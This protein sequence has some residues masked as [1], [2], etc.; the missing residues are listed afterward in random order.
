MN[1]GNLIVKT[2]DGSNTIKVPELDEHYHSVNGAIQ[3]ALTVFI[4][5]GIAKTTLEELKILEIGF[6]TGLN[7]LLTALE[8]KKLN[9]RVSYTTIEKYPVQEDLWT[10]LDY[11]KQTGEESRD[12]FY[13]LHRS[14]WEKEVIINEHFSMFKHQTDL[15][16]FDTSEKFDIIYYDA[17]A[18]S[19]QPSLWTRDIIHKVCGFGSGSCNFLTYAATGELKRQLIACNYKVERLPGPTGKREITRAVKG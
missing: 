6:G 4:N 16:Y 17:F 1:S 19:K 7:A 12:L 8:A 13:D 3:E 15:Q 18:R 5:P 9:K 10:M 2:A 14:D 11:H